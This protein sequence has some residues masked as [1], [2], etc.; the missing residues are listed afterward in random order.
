MLNSKNFAKKKKE[1]KK[2]GTANSYIVTKNPNNLF[3]ELRN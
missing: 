1:I 2:K 3:G